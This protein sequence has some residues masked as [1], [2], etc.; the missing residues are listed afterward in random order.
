VKD[1]AGNALVADFAWSFTTVA[2]DTTPPTLT[3]VT[4]ADGATGVSI[5][6]SATAVFNEPMDAATISTSTFELRSPSNNLVMAAVSYNSTTR[7]ATLTPS[8]SLPAA[9]LRGDRE[10]RRDGSTSE[11][12]RRQCI[13]AISMVVYHGGGLDRSDRGQGGLLR[14]SERARRIIQHDGTG[15][16]ARRVRGI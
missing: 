2:G 6:S 11:G 3:T 9:H 10:G 14:R 16:R 1:V 7:T 4:P 13:G 8:T 5:A 15:R 12:Y